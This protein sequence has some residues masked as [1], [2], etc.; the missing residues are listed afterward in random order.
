MNLQQEW[1]RYYDENFHKF[2]WFL[3]KL[4]EQYTQLKDA[5]KDINVKIMIQTMNNIWFL[6]PD[7]FNIINN[8]KGWNEFLSLIE[9]DNDEQVKQ[10]INGN[11]TN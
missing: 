8:P 3:E 10:I 6:L 7:S 9:F 5:R 11:T 2:E 1:L 4:P